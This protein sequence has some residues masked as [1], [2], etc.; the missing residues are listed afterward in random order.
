LVLFFFILPKI[1][2]VQFLND[3]SEV[4]IKIW[5]CNESVSYEFVLQSS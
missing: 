1:D 2:I 4:N 3:L 5:F